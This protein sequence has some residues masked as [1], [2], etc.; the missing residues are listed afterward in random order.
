[1]LVDNLWLATSWL[2]TTPA[3]WQ[4]LTLVFLCGVSVFLWLETGATDEGRN[5]WRPT[6]QRTIEPIGLLELFLALAAIQLGLAIVESVFPQLGERTKVWWIGC[7]SVLG[8]LL[9]FALLLPQ[10]RWIRRWLVVSPQ[11]WGSE[12]WL[13]IKRVMLVMPW[14][15]I[16]HAAL[17]RLIPYQHPTLESL[18]QAATAEAHL[19]KWFS[20]G[21]VAAFTEEYLY[22]AVLLY[23]F[24]GLDPRWH[25]AS[26][27]LIGDLILG[28]LVKVTPLGRAQR[29][30]VEDDATTDQR[31]PG[32]MLGLVAVSVVFALVHWGQGAAPV[33]LFF[34]SMFLGWLFIKT[35]SLWPCIAAHAF[36]NGYSLFWK[37]L[38]AVWK[39]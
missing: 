6:P 20:A 9:G 34:L 30:I 32:M 39:T 11:D 25:A 14:L 35:K 8:C 15:L 19:V 24:V 21:L 36:F 22:R 4:L 3:A 16:F 7:G 18:E 5:F 33:S 28:N 1:M 27:N 17:S 13:G 31:Q 29:G 26:R 10:S 37:S 12:C 38:E 23:W 2:A